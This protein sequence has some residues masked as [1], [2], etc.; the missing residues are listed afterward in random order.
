MKIQDDR[1]EEQRKTHRFAVVARD[2]FMSGWGGADGGVSRCA[3]ALPGDGS[4]NID[5]VENWVKDREEMRNVKVVDLSTYRAPKGT[6]HFHIYVV[7][8]KHPA[9]T[10]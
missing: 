2:K 1:T 8:A 10:H 5:R 9:A 7:D 6:V 3:W 4:V